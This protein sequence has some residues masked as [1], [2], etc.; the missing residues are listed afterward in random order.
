MLLFVIGVTSSGANAGVRSVASATNTLVDNYS[1]VAFKA[2]PRVLSVSRCAGVVSGRS[3]YF[4]LLPAHALLMSLQ[5][6]NT[7]DNR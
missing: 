1:P 2:N 4:K 3:S 6:C 5:H 7:K